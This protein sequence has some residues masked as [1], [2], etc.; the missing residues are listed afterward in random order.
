MLPFEVQSRVSA[1]GI[2]GPAQLH[3]P[4]EVGQTTDNILLGPLR[5]ADTV[6]PPFEVA[7]KLW[8]RT[9]ALPPRRD[10]D[11]ESVGLCADCDDAWVIES[12][13]AED[14]EAAMSRMEAIAPTRAR[15]LPV[16]AIRLG[17]RANS[18]ALLPL[19]ALNGIPSRHRETQR[20][21]VRC[22]RQK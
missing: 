5:L 20:G 18:P 2:P 16:A 22:T 11:S 21:N 17:L 4:G 13:Q 3:A 10:H 12:A 15:W 8:P 9:V 7:L 1:A 14:I 19:V 6:V